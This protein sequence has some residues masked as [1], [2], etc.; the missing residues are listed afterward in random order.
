MLDF[1][2]ARRTM[3]DSQL[4]TFDVTDRA[5]LAAM[6]AVPREHFMPAG[7]E[8]F[9]YSDLNLPVSD[10]HAGGGARFMLAPMVLARLIQA[11]GIEPGDRVL[12]VGAGL[13]YTSAVLA[14]LGAEPLALESD[15]A[16]AEA[17]RARLATEGESVEVRQGQLDRGCPE[18]GP[19]DAILINGALAQ[20]P[21]TLLRQLGEGGRL[22]CLTTGDRAGKAVIYL[23]TGDTFGLRTLFDAP[24]PELREFRPVPGFV[25]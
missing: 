25:F 6:A 21:D 9:A 24:G 8:E 13:G 16:L 15:A 18:D 20:R 4:R 19:F 1:A 10:S 3:V 11:L 22:A 2:Q 17:A 7:R 12:D 23:R 5:V 14:R